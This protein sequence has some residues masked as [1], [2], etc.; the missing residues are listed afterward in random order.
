MMTYLRDITKQPFIYESLSSNLCLLMAFF[1]KVER[2]YKSLGFFVRFLSLRSLRP[3]LPFLLKVEVVIC[4]IVIVP[5]R[6]AFMHRSA[7]LRLV[8]GVDEH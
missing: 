7:V 6:A 3:A 4:P 1:S 8:Q 5:L 2:K